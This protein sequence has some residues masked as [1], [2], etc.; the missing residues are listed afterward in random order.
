MDEEIV[1]KIGGEAG[2]GILSTGY[3]FS[4]I[5][6]K[7]GYYVFSTTEYPSLIRGGHNTYTVRASKEQLTS[8]TDKVDILLALDE[9]T[10]KKHIDEVK[11]GGV[12]IC[13]NSV[14]IK[15]RKGVKIVRFPFEEKSQQYGLLKNAM[16][17]TIGV[18]ICTKIMGIN[19]KIVEKM[20]INRF[21]A[22]GKEVIK[23]NIEAFRQGYDG[24]D[25]SV[26]D[27][28]VRRTKEKDM[29]LINGNTA[30]AIGAIRAGCNFMS[31]YPMTP[32]TS[33]MQYLAKKQD[34][35][36][37]LVHQSEDEI[38][39][40]NNALGASF[41]GARTLVATSGGGFALMNETISLSGSAEVPVVI[42]IAQRP[43]PATGLP[44][45]TEQG[46]LRFAIHAGHGDFPKVVVAPGDVNE[47]FDLTLQSFNIAERYQVP[48]I[49]L[50][51]KYLA[52]SLSTVPEF[53]DKG[54]KIDR[55][56]IV[57][58]VAKKLAPL[59]KYK[60]YKI[61]KDGISPRTIPGVENGIQCTIGDEHDEEGYI[62][63]EPGPRKEMMDKRMRKMELIQKEFKNRSVNVYG[64]RDSKIVLI[65]WGST[66]GQIIEAA[67]EL[68]CKF[69]QVKIMNPFPSKELEKK[70]GEYDHLILI[71]NNQ[72]GQLG[73]LIEEHTNLIITE[74]LLKYDGR[75]FNPIDIVNFVRDL[76]G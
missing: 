40:L 14:D 30:I 66:K 44:T 52:V 5:M 73:S 6:K 53:K 31:S 47:C 28:K 20:I 12:I 58:K 55:G 22:K 69:V 19:K 27:K 70:V 43:G 23:E 74:K 76:N 54:Y 15:E 41:A 71:E 68:K 36:N 60:R 32:A 72:T 39:A 50:T 21:K 29:I 26:F 62:V 49:I 45:R 75:P 9:L 16:K 8:H 11:G 37:I 25:S 64:N 42:V 56:L 4:Q 7:L 18:G 65:G 59:E 3:M 34:E 2:Y 48:V 13:D 35:Y 10:A 63:E 46:D 33:I 51:D 61:T 67:K 24:V 57:R 38:A 17:A 1:W